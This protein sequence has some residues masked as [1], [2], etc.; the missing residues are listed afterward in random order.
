M[1][2]TFKTI[3]TNGKVMSKSHLDKIDTMID[4]TTK[5]SFE[6]WLVKYQGFT[7]EEIK[8]QN[9]CSSSEWDYLYDEHMESNFYDKDL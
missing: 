6:D 2:K 9:H 5:L 4:E 1:L 3:N 8:C 7:I